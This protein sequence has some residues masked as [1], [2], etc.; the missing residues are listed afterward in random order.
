VKSAVRLAGA[1]G[2]GVVLG[3]VLLGEAALRQGRWAACFHAF[4][5]EARGG[6]ARGD[7]VIADE[8]LDYPVSREVDVLVALTQEAADRFAASVRAGGL[9]VADAG[10]VSRLAAGPYRAC[11]APVFRTAR[12]AVGTEAVGNVVALGVV[13]ALTDVVSGEAL[14][15]AVLQRFRGG[16]AAQNLRALE[17]GLALGRRLREEASR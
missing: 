13:S 10:R 1:G 17:A 5:P 3:S 9:V 16:A 12:E 6:A 14:E 2:Q 8:P 7:V 4:G 11:P 15:Q